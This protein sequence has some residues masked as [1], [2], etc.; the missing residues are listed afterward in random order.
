MGNGTKENNLTE[1]SYISNN[2]TLISNK[3]RKKEKTGKNIFRNLFGKLEYFGIKEIEI[4]IKNPEKKKCANARILNEEKLEDVLHDYIDDLYQ[5]QI[6][7]LNGY[8]IFPEKTL[9]E[10]L[11]QDGDILFMSDCISFFFIFT[12]GEKFIVVASKYQKFGDVFQKFKRVDCPSEF[13][14]KIAFASLSGKKIP[15]KDIISKIGI[16]ERDEISIMVQ[17]YN[18]VDCLY[19]EGIIALQRFNYIHIGEEKELINVKDIIVHLDSKNLD[20]NEM[21]EFSKINFIN[22]KIL[23]ITNCKLSS[24]EFLESETFF[25]LCELNMEYNELTH[26]NYNIYLPE[27]KILN[28]SKNKIK[29]ILNLSRSRHKNN[30]IINLPE[31]QIFYLSNNQIKDLSS[32]D[33]LQ[34]YKLQELYL[35]IN[36]IKSID[37]MKSVNFY[38]LKKIELSNNKIDNIDILEIASFKNNIVEINLMNN[39]IINLNVLRKVCLPHLIM[40]N[41]LNN[42]VTDFSVLQLLYFPN[43][44]Y[45]YIFPSTLDSNNFD[46]NSEIYQ[47]FYGYCKNIIEK[48]VEIRYSYKE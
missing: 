20:V 47:R 15:G 39:E 14:N 3:V 37:V 10:N 4:T 40:L 34:M 42:N 23:I 21:R 2:N 32:L 31:L 12:T 43:L 9:K 29:Q 38:E 5:S 6:I 35:N 41:L 28:L 33:K 48:G 24:L 46:K 13:K 19:D 27:L 16:K 30:K 44:K 17:N 11:V 45:L 8:E 36:D 22:L 18:N 26:L 25:H 7:T 1:T